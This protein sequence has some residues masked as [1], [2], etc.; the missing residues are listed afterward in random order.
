MVYDRRMSSP[1]NV[2][3]TKGR[4]RLGLQEVESTTSSM[5]PQAVLG[6]ENCQNLPVYLKWHLCHL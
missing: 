1:Q 5:R 4:Q 6:A 3:E 2:R